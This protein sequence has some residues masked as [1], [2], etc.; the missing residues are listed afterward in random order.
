MLYLC[1]WGMGVQHFRRRAWILKEVYFWPEYVI[2]V[3]GVEKQNLW[4]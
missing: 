1:F 3:I 4:K 2:W